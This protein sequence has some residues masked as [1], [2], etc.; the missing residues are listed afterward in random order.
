[1]HELF[2]A[3]VSEPGVSSNIHRIRVHDL[4]GEMLVGDF[5]NPTK[6]KSAEV[7]VEKSS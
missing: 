6:N 3:F 4:D 2:D 5:V 7:H 1:M